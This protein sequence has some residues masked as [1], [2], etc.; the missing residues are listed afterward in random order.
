MVKNKHQGVVASSF[1]DVIRGFGNSVV[2]LTFSTK[3]TRVKDSS[4][5]RR[6]R[7]NVRKN[8]N[9]QGLNLQSSGCSLG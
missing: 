8:P 2:I 3:F 6:L 5:Q 1:E 9:I 4:L 7:N